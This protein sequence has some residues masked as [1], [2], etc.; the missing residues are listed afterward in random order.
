M[1]VPIGSFKPINMEAAKADAVAKAEEA[2]RVH[3][4]LDERAR[5][6]VARTLHALPSRASRRGRGRASRRGRGRASSRGRASRRSR[7]RGRR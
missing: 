1:S 4:T 5:D 7:G 6:P 2:A 3:K